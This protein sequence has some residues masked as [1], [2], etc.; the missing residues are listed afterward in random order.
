MQTVGNK[1][2]VYILLKGLVDVPR[3]VERIEERIKKLKTQIDKLISSMNIPDY[4]KKVP[5]EVRDANSNKKEEFEVEIANLQR[6]LTGFKAL[7]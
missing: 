2:Q 3:E 7:K 4:E 5:V 1:C 6:A